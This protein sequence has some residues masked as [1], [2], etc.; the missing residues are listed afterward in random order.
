MKVVKIPQQRENIL[1]ILDDSDTRMEV[2]AINSRK[3]QK[4]SSINPRG[5]VPSF[6]ITI[7]NHDVVL[8]NCFFYSGATNNIIPLSFMEALGMG[9]TKY[10]ETGES[11]YMIDSRKVP[12]YGEI[13]Y[14]CAWISVS[15]HITTFFTI[16][17]VNLPPTYGVV[18]GR[19]WCSMIVGYIMND[20]SYMMFPKKYGTMV[21]VPQEARNTKSF[22]NKKN[23][24]LKNCIDV[25]I[26]NYV[27]L[28]PEKIHPPNQEEENSFQ[29]F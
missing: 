10:Y 16:I 11:I 12:T 1:N 15:P 3:Q 4:F 21:R 6:Y 28:S 27:V 18:V 19:D 13:K 22:R 7:E 17:V 8:H 23:E 29:G 20:G 25:E 5:K 14:F 9:C 24:V 26:R 2:V